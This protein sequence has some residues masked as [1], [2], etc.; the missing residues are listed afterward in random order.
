[1]ITDRSGTPRD[2][3]PERGLYRS[4]RFSPDGER[5]VHTNT[6]RATLGAD[7][8][9]TDVRDGSTMRV[10]SD[11]MYLA[12]EWSTDGRRI[13]FASNRTGD[14]TQ[15]FLISADAAGGGA[16]DTLLARTNRIYEHALTPDGKRILWRED[17]GLNA[18]DILSAEPRSST[19]RPERATR[20]DDRGIALS[21]DG[22]WYLYTSTGT[23][24]S[25]VHLSR[26]GG[27]GARWRVSPNGGAEPRWARNGEVFYRTLDAV[28]AT[29]VTLGATPR[30]EPPKALFADEF[31]YV[32]Y[33][34][35]WD[36]SADGERFVF[37]AVDRDANATLDL[38]VNWVARWRANTR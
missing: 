19:A 7:I 18:R 34:A 28:Y 10:T 25:E 35:V 9:V 32:G 16:F 2:V 5:I 8:F 24:R 14:A 31:Y 17:V 26:L 15:S 30:V 13:L 36:V 23:G 27:D 1:V 37:V 12:P 21:P 6:L 29:R 11:S 38:M 4:V 33:E 3:K 20:F 22:E